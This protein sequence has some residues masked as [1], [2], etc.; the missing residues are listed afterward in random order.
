M[1][2]SK[3]TEKVGKSAGSWENQTGSDP[4]IEPY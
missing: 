3:R 4:V 2:K 1:N